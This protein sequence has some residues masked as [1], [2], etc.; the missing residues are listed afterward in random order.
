M[1][2]KDLACAV[3]LSDASEVRGGTRGR[4]LLDFDFQSL[5]LGN[6]DI[7]QRS[8]Q[9]AFATLG[10]IN[11]PTTVHARGLVDSQIN[12]GSVN[13]YSPTVNQWQDNKMTN[14]V[15]PYFAGLAVG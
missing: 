12:A 3:E 2:I 1:E 6:T 11:A 4:A 13:S 7:S 15:N 8:N 10:G 14:D 9:F 5:R